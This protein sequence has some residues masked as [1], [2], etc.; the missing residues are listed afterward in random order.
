VAGTSPQRRPAARACHHRKAAGP[1]GHGEGGNAY[2][3]DIVQSGPSRRAPHVPRGVQG[4]NS[5]IVTF[6]PVTDVEDVVQTVLTKLFLAFADGKY[7]REAGS[8]RGWLQR[9][10]RNVCHDVW[11]RRRRGEVGAGD[12]AVQG[13]VEMAAAADDLAARIEREHDREVLQA[14]LVRLGGRVSPRDWQIYEALALRGQSPADVAAAHGMQ[15]S[16]VAE[17][18]SRAK[19][20][21]MEEVRRLDPDRG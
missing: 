10:V 4:W 11:D 20:K 8:F 3:A 19:K 2:V 17:V 12:P 9:V 1:A 7:R 5:C 14:A 21:L 6:F 13:V 15:V 18:K 16:A